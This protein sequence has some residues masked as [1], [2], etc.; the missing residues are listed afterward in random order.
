MLVLCFSHITFRLISLSRSDHAA[1]LVTPRQTFVRR[2]HLGWTA[3]EP[4]H[5]SRN[6]TVAPP[7]Q[8]RNKGELTKHLQRPAT[9][10]WGG[11][12]SFPPIRFERRRWQPAAADRGAAHAGQS[13]TCG[14]CSTAPPSATG[15][16]RAE[17]R[18]ANGRGRG[19][20]DR[21]ADQ[22]GAAGDQQP[23]DRQSDRGR[24]KP[25][26]MT[27]RKIPHRRIDPVRKS[28]RVMSG[29][30][31]EGIPAKKASKNNGRR[32]LCTFSLARVG[33]FSFPKTQLD[34]ARLS[35][36]LPAGQPKPRRELIPQSFVTEITSL[37]ACRLHME[38][39][40]RSP[41]TISAYEIRIGERQE[42]PHTEFLRVVLRA[43]RRRLC[44][45]LTTHLCY[46]NYE[47]HLGHCKIAFS[48]LK[49]RARVS[50]T[51][52]AEA[53]LIE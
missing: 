41:R 33:F 34:C 22:G 9:P 18:A 50:L 47:C 6:G 20:E 30:F 26:V 40:S 10:K 32:S 31:A 29:S 51:V 14:W 25:S 5:F 2:C 36:G 39:R 23:Q 3:S 11:A 44:A 42:S 52:R 7:P 37:V 24:R 35:A 45:R 46:C 8:R 43:N 17:S 15:S 1:G 21:G 38:A 27:V 48:V 28:H 19:R 4:P 13:W 12:L 53:A 16:A 49:E